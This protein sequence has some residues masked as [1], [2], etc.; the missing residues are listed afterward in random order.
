MLK[1]ETVIGLEVHAELNTASKIYCGCKNK[2][3]LEV[4]TAICP[5]CTGMPGTLPSLNSKVVEKCVK[6]GLALNCKVN[7]L[8]KQDRKNY[9]YPDLP[10]GYQIS[11]FDVPLCENGSLDIMING[12]TK[13][14][15]ITRIHIEEDAGKIVK[16]G[17][18]DKTFADYNRCGVP[19]IEIVSEPDMRSAEEAKAFLETI[20]TLL[21]Y[22][23]I[24][25]AKMQEGSVRC[26]VNVSIRPI[27][28]NELTT[29][30]EMKNV[31]S[32]GAVYRCILY[33]IG[34]QNTLLEAGR[35]IEQQTRRWDDEAGVSILLR[36]KEDA[37]DYRYFP[38]PDLLGITV[39]QSLID[40]INAELPELPTTKALRYIN[41]F[42][43]PIPDAVQIS[44]DKERALFFD[45]AVKPNIKVAK[46]ICNWII[47]DI[48]AYLVKNSISI[49]ETA[50]T[51]ENLSSMVTLI[52]NQIISNTAGKKVLEELLIRDVDPTA[53]VKD[54]NLTQINN[55]EI[56]NNI[57]TNVLDE[58]KSVI[59]DYKEGKTNTIGYFVGC[60]MKQSEGKG[61]P[62][63][64]TELLTDRLKSMIERRE[65]NGR[66]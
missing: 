55:N 10:K 43:L 48:A 20:H 4:N 52:D 66:I 44:S 23:D 28:T 39:S 11:Q 19:L 6:M 15:G 56:L 34:R 17:G 40:R 65:K 5:I 47:G 21:L 37:H 42:A 51:P 9:F 60:C 49:N 50:L 36:S 31:N 64:F 12:K 29:R 30:C 57:V 35:I 8:S 14:I 2:F 53:V 54:K 62:Q 58:N 13:L 7:K 45:A 18:V 16:M 27:G 38:E 59:L 1:Y 25:D 32:F 46:E 33:E 24:S 22:L 41:D 26:D 63:T 3:G 61:N